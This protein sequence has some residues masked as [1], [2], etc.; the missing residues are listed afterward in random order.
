MATRHVTGRSSGDTGRRLE[1]RL[2]L[3]QVPDRQLHGLGK[4]SKS[5]QNKKLNMQKCRGHIQDQIHANGK[6]NGCP[7][8]EIRQCKVRAETGRKVRLAAATSGA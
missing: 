5:I 2:D 6:Q 4:A 1:G 7:D 8:G 3:V